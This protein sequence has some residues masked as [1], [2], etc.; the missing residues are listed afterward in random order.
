MKTSQE[1][2]Q[3]VGFIDELSAEETVEMHQKIRDRA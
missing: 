3:D 1:Y 2:S